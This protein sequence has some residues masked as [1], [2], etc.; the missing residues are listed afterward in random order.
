MKIIIVKKFVSV[1]VIV[2]VIVIPT[3]NVI[4]AAIAIPTV[5]AVSGIVPPARRKTAAVRHVKKTAVKF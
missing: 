3:V 5:I 2:T 4:V 1:S